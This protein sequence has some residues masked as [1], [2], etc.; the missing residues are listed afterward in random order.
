MRL[1]GWV[2]SSLLLFGSWGSAQ[3]IRTSFFQSFEK[4]QNR[5]FYVQ[6]AGSSQRIDLLNVSC[7][8]LMEVTYQLHNG[9]RIVSGFESLRQYSS[10]QEFF[11]QIHTHPWQRPV[12]GAEKLVIA[13]QPSE[14]DHADLQ[15]MTLVNET[16]HNYEKLQKTTTNSLHHGRKTKEVYVFFPGVT[17][18]ARYFYW[19]ATQVFLSG[20]NV[21]Y[22]T[23]PGQEQYP[24]LEGK[25]DSGLWLLYAEYLARLAKSYGEKVIL[26]G[27]STGGLLAIRMAEVKLAD[28]IILMQPLIKNTWLHQGSVEL[29]A[30][31]VFKAESQLALNGMKITEMPFQKIDPNIKVQIYF[32][33]YDPFVYNPNS[34]EW[35]RNFA[36]HA[37]SKTVPLK[38]PQDLFMGHMNRPG[39]L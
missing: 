33:D 28:E 6:Q 32:A 30:K 12:S 26:V 20:K 4:E 8:N 35:I 16:F 10:C 2:I 39:S 9:G 27:Q 25:S 36:P 38:S 23:L 24:L 15:A 29:G 17:L 22:G 13:S 21:I 31:L 5:Q 14:F 1:H 3:P 19:L 37:I 7:S 34:K 18:S 11:D